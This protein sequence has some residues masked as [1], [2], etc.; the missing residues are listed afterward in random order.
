MANSDLRGILVGRCRDGGTAA[1]LAAS[2][3]ARKAVD[4]VRGERY[5][6]GNA[7]LAA[8]AHEPDT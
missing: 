7:A 6:P 5:T 3:A 4:R 1:R 2:A 8:N